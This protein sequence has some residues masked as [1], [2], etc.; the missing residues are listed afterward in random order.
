M[1][2]INPPIKIIASE[3]Y[4]LVILDASGM[5]HYFNKDG[6]YDGWSKDCNKIDCNW[7]GARVKCFICNHEWIAVF[8]SD[9]ERLECPH[10]HNMVLYEVIE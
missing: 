2:V 10:C 4:G 8:S 9:C 3:N 5:Y 7:S 1:I 6:S